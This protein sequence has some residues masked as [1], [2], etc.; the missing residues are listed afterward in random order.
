[1]P[2]FFE[3]MGSGIAGLAGGAGSAVF[4]AQMQKRQFKHQKKEAKKQRDFQERMSSTSHQRE[5]RDLEASGLNRILS[6]GKGANTPSGAQ[7]LVPDYSKTVDS[8][9]SGFRV[10]QEAALTL[11]NIRKVEQDTKT[12]GAQE[13]NIKADTDI[14]KP[15]AAIKGTAGDII[16]GLLRKAGEFI[17][18]GQTQKKNEK[19]GR[20]TIGDRMDPQADKLKRW[21]DAGL[22]T[23]K[24]YEEQLGF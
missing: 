18:S 19:T 24:E 6:L 13:A 2:G 5:T 17:T 14:K 4:S 10:A 7:A 8:A 3:G 21:L 11:A 23:K 22:I 1:M 20:I 9:Q 12:S 16:E 15:E